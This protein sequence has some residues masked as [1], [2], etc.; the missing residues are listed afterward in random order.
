MSYD[1]FVWDEYDLLGIQPPPPGHR[2][3]RNGPGPLL[4]NRPLRRSYGQAP[5]PAEDRDVFLR[6]SVEGDLF[7]FAAGPTLVKETEPWRCQFGAGPS[8][9][10]VTFD[11]DHKETDSRG[12]AWRDS[13]DGTKLRLGA[14]VSG[15]VTIEVDER[16][17]VGVVGRYDWLGDVSGS[18]G[19]SDYEFDLQGWSVAAVVGRD[20]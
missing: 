6:Q 12:R 16:I 19:P 3:S 15:D 20:L 17:H 18:V 9:N 10:I 13:D 4:P 8:L 14:F 2:G 7:T 5:V 11:A 1:N